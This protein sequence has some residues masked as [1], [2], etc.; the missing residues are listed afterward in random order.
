MP[1][2]SRFKTVF[3]PDFEEQKCK[4]KYNSAREKYRPSGH[5]TAGFS[6]WLESYNRDAP[7]GILL[8]QRLHRLQLLRQPDPAKLRQQS[9]V[10]DKIT[11][12]KVTGDIPPPLYSEPNQA[13]ANLEAEMSQLRSAYWQHQL[14]MQDLYAQSSQVKDSSY[15]DIKLFLL[16][17]EYKNHD[18]Y[19]YA[20]V[21]SAQ[22]CA[23]AGGCCGRS[24]RCC[25]KA[26]YA[27]EEKE[28][29]PSPVYGHCTV[30]C[31]C[32]IQER[33]CYMPDLRL[34]ATEIQPS[35]G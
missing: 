31:A 23:N 32:C 26:L 15:N 25:W 35:F 22:Q 6:N 20:F 24:C 27:N 5:M 19:S 13:F 29:K 34:P 10:D 12:A 21:D 8:L 30:E 7:L 1:F 4:R 9:G 18:G 11:F 17:H 2:W 33:G 16:G 3:K 28:D 14:R